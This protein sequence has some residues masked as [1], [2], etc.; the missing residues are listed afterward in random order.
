MAPRL[1]PQQRGDRT[2]SEAALQSRILYR[3]RKHGWKVAHA[4]RGHV[5]DEGQMV[6]PMAKG[7]PDLMLF[8]ADSSHP[9]M[10]WELKRELG[11]ASDEQLAWLAIMNAC[12]I[13]AVI[14]R[15]SDLRE[16]RVDLLLKT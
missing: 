6:T 14:I 8:K 15:P 16:K 2:M 11:K 7:W 10:A 13:P 4:G 3:T 5:G 9:V 12:G 1:T